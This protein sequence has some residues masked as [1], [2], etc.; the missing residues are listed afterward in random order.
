MKRL[1]VYF[2]L[3]VLGFSLPTSAARSLREKVAG[4]PEQHFIPVSVF[5]PQTNLDHERY[6]LNYCKQFDLIQANTN[7]LKALVREKP[8][9]I[10]IS[11]PV[12]GQ[13]QEFKLVRNEK[14]GDETM[15]TT[16]NE[17]V[18]TPY[19]YN[20][21]VFY[22]GYL[23][24]E[25][26]SVAAL[27]F[28]NHTMMGF[29]STPAGN[30]NIG[31]SNLWQPIENEFVVYN[32]KDALFELPFQCQTRNNPFKT[33]EPKA[34]PETLTSK[35]V[36]FYVECDHKIYTDFSSN[37]TNATNYA[38]GLLN[39][40]ITL[41][42]NDSIQTAVNQL[43]IWT[44]ADPYL[45]A[46]NTGDLLDSFASAM[47]GG[48]NGDLAHL[49][50]RRSLGGGVAYLDILC[51]N[52]PYYQTGISASL[53]TTI[54]PLPTYSWNSTVITHEIGHNM[55]SPH[56]HACEWNGNGTRIDNCAGNYNVAYQEGTCNSYPPNPVA[57]GTIMSY[58]HLQ[59][60]GI[61]LSLGFGPQP[62]TLIRNTVNAGTCLGVCDTCANNIT[63]TGNFN[64]PYTESS[65]W[66]KTSGVTRIDSSNAVTLDVDAGGYILLQ[67]LS[68]S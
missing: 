8:Q 40:T 44:S 3:L 59:A 54:T 60:V 34:L 32:E 68:A 6:L 19:T 63:I 66:I 67:A 12:N 26:Q 45:P 23:S 35:C 2:G 43:T 28:F 16:K 21:G 61:N 15:F 24:N 9:A 38:T 41:Y 33:N 14:I 52:L 47:S 49:M 18:E 20:D 11:L 25:T 5:S 50:S 65:T 42:L 48:F 53:S 46:T 17:H 30:F 4:I 36:K 56:T 58:C 29:F 62:G 37:L 10:K 22:H 31:P 64:T 13:W 27:S 55:A 1:I 51:L 39:N 57:G 7:T